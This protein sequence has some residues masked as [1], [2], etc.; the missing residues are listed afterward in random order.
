[1][2]VLGML[3]RL[4]NSADNLYPYASVMRMLKMSKGMA[5]DQNFFNNLQFVYDVK[6]QIRMSYLFDID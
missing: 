5:Y 2:Y 1:M 3:E 4:L 6:T